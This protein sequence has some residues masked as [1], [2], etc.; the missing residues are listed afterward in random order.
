MYLLT[1]ND[2]C[3]ILKNLPN[4]KILRVFTKLGNIM[5]KEF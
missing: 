3:F 2:Q 5:K 4:Y 1:D